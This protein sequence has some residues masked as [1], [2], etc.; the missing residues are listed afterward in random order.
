MHQP[1]VAGTRF[2][3]ER[4]AKASEPKLRGPRE[5]RP[6]LYGIG[7]VCCP[8]RRPGTKTRRQAPVGNPSVAGIGRA[9]QAPVFSGAASFS[10]EP[11]RLFSVWPPAGATNASRFRR[12]HNRPRGARACAPPFFVF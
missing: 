10:G 9:E 7:M 8:A 6:G 4:A 2:E 1:N 5:E 12:P 3:R 11:P